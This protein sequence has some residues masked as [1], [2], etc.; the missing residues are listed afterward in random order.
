MSRRETVSVTALTSTGRRER[1]RGVHLH[2]GALGQRRHPDG[3]ADGEGP[4]EEGRVDVV[5]LRELVHV[6]QVDADPSGLREPGA[7]SSADGIE[8][9]QATARLLGDAAVDELPTGRIE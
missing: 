1:N 4:L 2:Q 9:L 7:G 8:A 5:D 6:R 3:R